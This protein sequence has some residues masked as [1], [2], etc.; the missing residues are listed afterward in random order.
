MKH[1]AAALSSLLSLPCACSLDASDPADDPIERG[2]GIEEV[3]L[4]TEHDGK[5]PDTNGPDTNGP[6]SCSEL[7]AEAQW[8]AKIGAS[9]IPGV[10]DL[11]LAPED[12]EALQDDADGDGLPDGQAICDDDVSAAQ[13]LPA[14]SSHFATYVADHGLRCGCTCGPRSSCDSL[15]P[16][17][18]HDAVGAG[19]Y[20]DP[21]EIYTAEQLWDLA[22]APEGW[23]DSFVQCGDIDLF[24]F[25]GPDRPYFVIP[26]LTGD[27]DGQ[28]HAIRGFRYDIDGPYYSPP[29]V[30]ANDGVTV[31]R[32]DDSLVALFG[33]IEGSVGQLRLLDATVRVDLGDTPAHWVHAGGLAGYTTGE[34]WQITATGE[35]ETGV[36]ANYAGALTA[37]LDGRASDITVDADVRGHTAGGLVGLGWMPVIFRATAHATVEAEHGAGAIAGTVL[38]ATASELDASGV[39]VAGGFGGGAFGTFVGEL[40]GARADA[41]VVSDYGAGGL[42]GSLKGQLSRAS[43]TGVAVGSSAGGL[44]GEVGVGTTI[45]D[46][47]AATDVMGVG[48]PDD[49]TVSYAGGVVGYVSDSNPP[50][51]FTHVYA[52][53]DVVGLQEAGGVVGHSGTGFALQMCFATGTVSGGDPL[54]FGHVA[55]SVDPV[56]RYNADTNPVVPGQGTPASLAAGDFEDPNASF[57]YTWPT[58]AGGWVFAPGQLPRLEP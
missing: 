42:A 3:E 39:I 31:V 18:E 53:G 4:P 41:L 26:S 58:G 52:A 55:G 5:G 13:G 16:H 54:P 30:L 19:T 45:V 7:V 51:A 28:G 57:G 27:Y 24:G 35:V 48:S 11:W 10:A 17:V 8:P 9:G 40:A 37:Q 2:G 12:C 15:G 47:Y 14:G 23:D 36:I 49:P 56:N 43:A 34:V 50:V 21:Y 44:V 29:P 38:Y 25:Y 20:A 46:S 22:H 33:S 1:P 32:G 6:S